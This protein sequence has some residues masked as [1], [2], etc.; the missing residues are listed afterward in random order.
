VACVAACATFGAS[1]SLRA[2]PAEVSPPGVRYAIQVRLDPVRHL[3]DGWVTIRYRSGADT[4][5]DAI[6]L[7]AYPNA[8]A[9]HRTIYAR[10]AERF[11]EDYSLR[12]A[13]ASDRGWMTITDA[14]VDGKSA[15]V[16]MDE[17]LARVELPRPLAPGD[18]VT[19]RA[20]FRVQIPRVFDRF[21]R[22]G[23]SYAIAQWYPK[24]V[25]YDEHGW[26]R[27]PYHYFA[28][29]YGEFAAYDVTITLPDEQWVGA[30]GT[31]VSAV[32]GDNEIPLE[33]P[34]A[35][36]VSVR[37]VTAGADSLAGRWPSRGLFLDP[38][39]G[40]PIEVPRE[41][42]A[43]WRVPR[44]AP[45]HYRYR[46][47]DGAVRSS[48]ESDDEGRG[49]PLRL[50]VAAT[51]TTLADSIRLLVPE[52]APADSASRSL[53]T[54]QFHAEGVHDF[55]WVASPRYVR[56]DT[57]WNGVAVRTLLFAEDAATWR[58]AL[59]FT[60]R[61]LEHHAAW[62]G[63]YP[64]PQFTTAEAQTAGG[65]M[66]YPMLIMNDP[67]LPD[68]E[69]EWLDATIAHEAGHD[70]FYGT[71]ANDE[72]RDPWLD[73][74][75]TQYL[76]GRYLDRHYPRG[77]WKRRDRFRW[78]A[79]VRVRTND[80][81]AVL[82]RH[83]A[84]DEQPP[85]DPAD[86]SRGYPGYSVAAY[87]RPAVMLHSLERVWG[88]ET[89]H[90]FL[91][92]IYRRR[93]GRHV[94]PADVYEAARAAAGDGAEP[95]LR[96]WI[97]TTDVPDAAL[98]GIRRERIVEGWRTTVTVRRKGGITMPVPLEARFE[99][100]TRE[101][102][103]VPTPERENRVVF[104]SR[105]RLAGA[106]LD[107]DGR[108]FD[109][110]RLDDR[111]GLLPPMRWSPFVDYATPDAMTVLYGPTLWWGKR[112][113][114]RLGAWI[115]GRY[116]PGPDFPRGIRSF[117]AGANVGTE[118]GSFA[119]RLG[120]GRRAGTLGARGTV[121]LLAA[122]DVRYGRG[123]ITISNHVTGPGRLHPWKTWS[124]TLRD[125]RDHGDSGAARRTL[126]AGVSL[127]ME[128]KGPR[129]QESWSA[130]WWRG[131][132]V[133]DGRIDS[134]RR[135]FDR[136]FAEFT[137]RLD[138]GARGRLHLSGRVAAGS[139][140]RSAPRDRLFD[141]A[142][143]TPLE[144]LDRFEWNDE[145]P[146]RR[147]EHA[148]AEGGGGL[149]GY[150]GRNL[151][152]DRMGAASFEIRHDRW[153]VL[154]FADAG[155]VG[156]GDSGAASDSLSGRTIADAGVGFGASWLRVYAPFWVGTPAPGERPWDVRWVVAF[157]L[158]EIRFR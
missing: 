2:A 20:R 67:G 102:R 126:D 4:T 130:S 30:T 153:P 16:R 81:R 51:D 6:W 11:G 8:F 26:A 60:V 129:R 140:D 125:L 75:F 72:R 66:E 150:V 96:S 86:S 68:G 18:S 95:L 124:L 157:T 39:G 138:L 118:D 61:A 36:S 59:E 158:P 74:G 103:I 12:F 33:R 80:T 79:P 73:E 93:A 42:G 152:A 71:I 109:A 48:W 108:A 5:L 37:I 28:E 85:S 19:L 84:R 47:D 21:G 56:A 97:E 111:G 17:T 121:R 133:R 154:L 104:E 110:Y 92:E 94:R 139:V 117:E 45:M 65:A 52:P 148:W 13:P 77:I 136:T 40:A 100:G 34:A 58:R 43:L 112:E 145:G 7:H 9:D 46:W 3:L 120:Y 135:G 44:G 115:E 82:Q 88:E 116:L 1:S 105:A 50:L 63:P 23:D 78:V 31:L 83:Y 99:D 128:T 76:E 123:E 25:V 70:W 90:S 141:A 89:M 41:G 32:G 91:S 149:R 134:W 106:A 119:W 122:D 35:D 101:T 146:L 142:Q 24:V 62:V 54:L 147:S 55:A 57:V 155:R 144:T 156:L 127:A 22:A 132:R 10:E 38:V 53:K 143:A 49:A 69:V 114:A 29:F 87:D 107:P 64:W 98:G 131:A 27:D 113:G 137:Q 151:L 15:W 14:T